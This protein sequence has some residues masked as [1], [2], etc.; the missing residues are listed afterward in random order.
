MQIPYRVTKH[1][2]HSIAAVTLAIVLAGRATAAVFTDD[3]SGGLNQSY[4]LVESSQLGY[5]VSTTEGGMTFARPETDSGQGF[6]YAKLT[7]KLVASGAFDVQVD[8]TNAELTLADGGSA[9]QV[10]LV[11]Y[12]GGRI[13]YTIRSDESGWGQ[14]AHAWIYNAGPQAG[15]FGWQGWEGTSGTLRITHGRTGRMSFW[16]GKGSNL[17]GA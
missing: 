9:N 15:T 10:E 1:G 13:F 8:F 4:W 5:T 2:T 14:S 16:V 17:D 7:S 11:C 3:F 12:M 6:Q